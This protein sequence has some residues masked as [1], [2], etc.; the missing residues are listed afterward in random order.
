MVST[1]SVAGRLAWNARWNGARLVLAAAVLLVAE[2][3]SVGPALAA[4][5]PATHNLQGSAIMR[6][7]DAWLRSEYGDLG[8]VADPR[9]RIFVYGHGLGR[10]A[11]AVRDDPGR[12]ALFDCL[13]IGVEQVA[14][15]SEFLFGGV[16]SGAKYRLVQEAAMGMRD[17]EVLRATGVSSGAPAHAYFDR[18]PPDQLA[19]LLAG[20]PTGS[21][22]GASAGPGSAGTFESGIDRPGGDYT[23][24]DLPS[25]NPGLCRQRCADESRCR[26]WTY[27]K[28]GVQGG[29]ARCWLKS[30][31][32][33]AVARA[34]C[35]SG[36]MG[37]GGGHQVVGALETGTDRP[38]GDYTSFDLPSAD[39][40]LCR[41][42]CADES[43]CRAWTYVK[44]GVQG[45]KARCWLKSSEPP[46]VKRGCCVSG[47]MGR[48]GGVQT[49]GTTTGQPPTKKHPWDGMCQD[50]ILAEGYRPIFALLS[51]IYSDALIFADPVSNQYVSVSG[52]SKQP[53]DLP[54]FQSE[55]EEK[56]TEY[57]TY[58]QDKSYFKKVA[59]RHRTTGNW[60]TAAYFRK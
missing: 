15:S 23:S 45:N 22:Q 11:S 49:G 32:P 10:V 43:R 53:F 51:T 39:P 31:E 4:G 47:L 28:P 29:N 48:A 13:Q 6:E 60:V 16:S 17:E 54:R 36:V 59:Y 27:V 2:A 37:K 30:S 41:Q 55:H 38:G 58:D 24:F 1:T 40:G 33:P 7:F 14:A 56:D 12:K 35:T 42:R 20:S 46:A 44:P 25:A 50:K 9:D 8:R 57:P 52:C 26:A 19:G 34:C 3:L 18:F 5:C 21:G